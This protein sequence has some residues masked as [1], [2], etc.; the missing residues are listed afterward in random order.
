MTN[1]VTVCIKKEQKISCAA[2]LKYM[3][4]MYSKRLGEQQLGEPPVYE[5]FRKVEIEM[6]RV[7]YFGRQRITETRIIFFSRQH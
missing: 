5:K 1:C 6:R 2:R 4:S 7:L 3:H